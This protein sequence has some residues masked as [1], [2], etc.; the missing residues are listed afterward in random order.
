MEIT[1]VHIEAIHQNI[2][3]H[4]SGKSCRQIEHLLVLDELYNYLLRGWYPCSF[5]VALLSNDLYMALHYANEAE[6]LVL[7]ELVDYIKT[8]APKQAY[9]SLEEYMDWVENA[10]WMRP[11]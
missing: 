4:G 3:M 6:A 9:G 2:F 11:A 10:F 8:I 1:S 7:C 5:L